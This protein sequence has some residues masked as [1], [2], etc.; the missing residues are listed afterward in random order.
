MTAILSDVDMEKLARPHVARAWFARLDFPDGIKYLHSGTGR[1]TIGEH[2]YLGVSD[3][4]SGRLVSIAQVEEPQFGT[5]AAV[6][7]VLSGASKEFIQSVHATARELEGRAA[8]IYWAA[9]DGETQ[10][11]ITALVPLFPRGRMSSPTIHW[12][13]I[14]QRHVS[15]TI[16]NI[17]SSKNFAPGGKWNQA[18]QRRRFPGDKGL[19]FVGVKVSENWQ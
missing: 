13:G 1:I 18:D 10:E 19:D 8:T 11:I 6:Q 15:L 16:E 7:I 14:G 4:L 5:A 3:P 17:W 9:F 2:E 12:Q